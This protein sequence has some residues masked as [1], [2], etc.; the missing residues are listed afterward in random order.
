MAGENRSRRGSAGRLLRPG[1]FCGIAEEHDVRRNGPPHR[2]V[3]LLGLQR[4][5]PS[6][7]E[8]QPSTTACGAAGSAARGRVSRLDQQAWTTSN[9]YAIGDQFFYSSGNDADYIARAQPGGDGAARRSTWRALI[10]AWARRLVSPAGAWVSLLL[11]V[12][13]PTFLAHGPLVTSDMAA[14]LFFTAA[15]GAIWVALHRVTR[16]PCWALQFSWPARSSRS[17]PRRS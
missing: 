8:R 2:R 10:Y 4:L 12:F 1:R 11:F 14:A 7:R 5:P 3:H 6:S 16:R 9:V 15:A 13:S 17:C